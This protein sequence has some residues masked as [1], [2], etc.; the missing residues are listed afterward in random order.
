[1]PGT[2]YVRA[3]VHRLLCRP[4]PGGRSSVTIRSR[5]RSRRPA[6]RS[7]RLQLCTGKAL[8]ISGRSSPIALPES[9]TAD[10]VWPQR[11][12]SAERAPAKIVTSGTYGNALFFR[13]FCDALTQW[14]KGRVTK[15]AVSNDFG[16]KNA[17]HEKSIEPQTS[18]E[19]ALFGSTL[20][21]SARCVLKRFAVTI[22][23]PLH[24]LSTSPMIAR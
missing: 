15:R 6:R 8:A 5:S 10:D 14:R 20:Q 2:D 23:G 3:R 1:M 7:R 13:R 19:G 4:P 18:L 24:N 9:A 17:S 21:R 12:R 11:E 16:M 22:R